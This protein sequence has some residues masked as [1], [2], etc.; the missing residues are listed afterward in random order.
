MP[1]CAPRRKRT[2][3]SGC[4][5][6]IYKPP[7]GRLTKETQIGE[8][9]TGAVFMGHHH[10]RGK[11]A[12]KMANITR[13]EESVCR[14]VNFLLKFS[15]HRNIAS[16]YGA[17]YH[18]APNEESSEYLELVLEYCSGGSLYDLIDSTEGQSLK[19]TWIG[20]VC[21]EV[22]KTLNHIHNHQAVHRDI[23]SPNVMLTKKG[24]I[25]LIDF[26]LCWDLDPQTGKCNQADGTAHWMAPE[27][28]RRRDR[29]PEFDTK[30]DIWSLGI[31]AIEMAEGKTPYADQKLVSELII[32]N[33]SPRLISRT[34]S[35]TFVS[36]LESCLEKDPSRRWSAEELLQ[37]PFITELPPAKTIRAEIEEHLRAVQNR[38]AKQGLRAVRWA[39]KQLR[40]AREHLRGAREQ[41]R[42]RWAME[43][44]RRAR[45]Q[46]QR[47]REQ[48]RRAR[49]QLRP[50]WDMEHLRRACDFCATET[51]PEQKEAQQMA[52]EGFAC[53]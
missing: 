41:L 34:W 15:R 39:R 46:L 23:K 22:L 29:E 1:F 28:F 52:L 47:A 11:V 9:G 20:Y 32:N 45:E 21:R 13:D 36:F 43:Q 10:R 33:D 5:S 12:V 2:A 38:P 16:Y 24:N 8:G 27:A 44:L 48:L 26:G 53:V 30:C 4:L 18:P 42:T 14:E 37:H 49:E 31:T 3:E 35:Q 6:E 40:R 25:K 19:E 17:Y 50:R 7:D 51:S